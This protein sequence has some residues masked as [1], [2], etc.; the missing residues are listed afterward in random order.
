LERR[1][2]EL[3]SP[4]GEKTALVIGAIE[5]MTGEFSVSDLLDACPGVSIDLIRRTLKKIR[6]EGRVECLGMGRN[7]KWR[8]M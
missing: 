2:G 5:G 3:N 4:R 8:R 7:A 6:G 1:V